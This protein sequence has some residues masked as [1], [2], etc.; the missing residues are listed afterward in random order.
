[1]AQALTVQ[2][3]IRA[4]RDELDTNGI[5]GSEIEAKQLIQHITGYSPVELV[6]SARALLSGEQLAELQNLTKVRIAGVPLAHLLGEV[7]F[8]NLNLKSDKRAL[9]PRSDSEAIIRLGLRVCDESQIKKIADLGTGTGCL[10][11]SFLSEWKSTE[12]LGVDISPDALK[13]AQ[14]NADRCGLQSRTKWQI[15]N[16]FDAIKGKFDLI[17]S[18]PPYIE[19]EAI[20]NLQ[21]EVREHD[22]FLALDGGVDGLLAYKAIAKEAGDYLAVDGHLIVEIG[23][24]QD[25][26][27]KNIMRK[28]GLRFIDQEADLNGIIRTL[29]FA[30]N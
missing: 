5:E 26:D 18:N 2:N 12:G 16:W 25:E 14:E 13:L 24:G 6:T 30:S 10:L 4:I 23:K 19:T 3:V 1:M 28:N 15:S 20:K 11:L 7:Q 29:A 17:I 8:W 21:T 22:P 9:I 27:V